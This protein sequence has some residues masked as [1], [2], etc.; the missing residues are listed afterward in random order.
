MESV[1]YKST[2]AQHWTD[3]TV[4][5][6][7]A[8]QD[9][10]T[11]STASM[12]RKPSVK[13]IVAGVEAVVSSQAQTPEGLL[14]AVCRPADGGKQ[15]WL[16]LQDSSVE[17]LEK[18]I[19]STLEAL[20][21][22]PDAAEAVL[23]KSFGPELSLDCFALLHVLAP[24]LRSSI[25]LEAAFGGLAAKAKGECDIEEIATELDAILDS[26]VEALAA[27]ELQLKSFKGP[28]REESKHEAEAVVP[29]TPKAAGNSQESPQA[30]TP[31]EAAIEADAS[32]ASGTPQ[33]KEGA[34]AS[35]AEAGLSQETTLATPTKVRKVETA[36][37]ESALEESQSALNG[38]ALEESQSAKARTTRR[39]GILRRT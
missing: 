38:T 39:T 32:G 2:T 9:L 29:V 4:A 11:S 19:E 10:L 21:L 5:T 17:E 28:V 3:F 34:T 15:F 20:K 35:S 31:N 12:N 14:M 6:I 24:A 26:S 16:T 23:S 37:E 22:V 27:C 8:V 13:G 30:H 18:R 25:L 1:A 36:L 33:T 7:N